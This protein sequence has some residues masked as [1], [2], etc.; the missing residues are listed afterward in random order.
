MTRLHALVA[1]AVLFTVATVAT[2]SDAAPKKPKKPDATAPTGDTPFDRQAAAASL[3]SIDLSKCKST[4][5]PKGD[6]HVLVKFVPAGSASDA[7]VDKG[8]LVGTP[9]A[10]CIA[11]EFKK[12][13]VPAFTG[14][15][16]SV[17]KS[18][19]FE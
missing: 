8:Q 4:N 11:K 9:T 5:T 17:G 3:S 13:K 19:H 6:G 16:V 1:S 18:F 10:R 7:S 12:A 2:G 14:D 15:T